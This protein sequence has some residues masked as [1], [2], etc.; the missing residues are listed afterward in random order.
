VPHRPLHCSRWQDEAAAAELRQLQLERAEQELQAWATAS[1]GWSR[2]IAGYG[3]SWGAT[4]QPG[5]TVR[6]A[7]IS[8]G[9]SLY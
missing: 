2:N 1:R 5:G 7:G 6:C 9:Y 3:P 8:Y 4:R